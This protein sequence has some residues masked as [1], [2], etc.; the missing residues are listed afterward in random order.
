MQGSRRALAQELT[1]AAARRQCE[2]EGSAPWEG[3]TVAVGPRVEAG[4]RAPPWEPWPV[5]CCCCLRPPPPPPLLLPPLPPLPLPLPLTPPRGCEAGED[6][7]RQDAEVQAAVVEAVRAV[8]EATL[9]SLARRSSFRRSMFTA[10]VKV[11]SGLVLA[12]MSAVLAKRG[13]MPFSRLSTSWRSRMGWP[14]SRRASA[15]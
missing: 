1:P 5:C 8:L 11:G 4:P 9:L 13:L 7:E 6:V 14:T 12:M 15:V 10:S 3:A 2:P